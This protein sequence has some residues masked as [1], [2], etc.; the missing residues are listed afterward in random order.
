VQRIRLLKLVTAVVI[1][2]SVSLAVGVAVFRA[3]QSVSAPE[4]ESGHVHEKAGQK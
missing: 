3:S 2:L 1:L 4:T